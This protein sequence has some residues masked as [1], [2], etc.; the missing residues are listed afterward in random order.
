MGYKPDLVDKESCLIISE[1]AKYKRIKDI[2]EII[3]RY[4]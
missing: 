4:H 2:S 1:V 3:S